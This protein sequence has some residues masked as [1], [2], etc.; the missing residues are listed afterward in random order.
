LG[1]VDVWQNLFQQLHGTRGWDSAVGIVTRFGLDGPGIESRWWARFFAPVQ[2]SP[3]AHPAFYTKGTGSFPQV[4]R[5][6]H[7]VDHP[8]T[9]SAKVKESVELH[10]CSSSGPE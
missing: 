7:G 3:G 8:P 1:D 4:K 10:L 6:G 5:L 2:T 9:A